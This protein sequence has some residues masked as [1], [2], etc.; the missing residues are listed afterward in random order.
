M[1]KAVLLIQCP[2]RKG[3]V[4]KV[5]QFVFDHDCNIIQSDQYTTDPDGGHFFMRL[6]F[7]FDEGALAPASLEE[8]FG[9]LAGSLDARWEIH[10]ESRVM[11]MAIA[12]SQYDH[13]LVDLL[14]R[15]SH[16]E[17]TVNIPFVYS[18]HDSLRSLVES[19]GIEFHHLPVTKETKA[20]QEKRCLELLEG[21]ADF[22]V[23]ARYMQILSKEFL[24]QYAGDVINIHHSFLPSF[25]GANP[26]R[27][28]FDRGVKVIGATTHYATADLDEGPIIEQ[29]VDHVTHRDTVETLKR[30]GRNLEQRAL[31][32]TIHAHIEHR[33]I[34]FKSKTIV[35][36]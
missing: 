8:E 1:Q 14:Y 23:L 25:K 10:Y 11:N 16:G 35:F 20:G 28:A 15:V 5:S 12:V 24:E 6:E 3:I 7:Y 33:I 36:E 2:D 26:Y 29:A 13:C 19:H 31:A 32:A 18:N 21:S 17:L 34:R 22:L 30:K 27:Q 4:A 9:G